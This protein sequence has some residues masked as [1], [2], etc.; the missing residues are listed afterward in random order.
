MNISQ[1][2]PISCNFSKGA[3]LGSCGPREKVKK[4]KSSEFNP[5]N[6]GHAKFSPAPKVWSHKSPNPHLKNGKK[7]HNA[8][9]SAHR[10]NSQWT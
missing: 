3:N 9:W 8:K 4:G 6:H 7:F 5:Q 1:M 10:K 2:L